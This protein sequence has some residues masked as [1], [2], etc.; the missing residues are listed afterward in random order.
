[1]GVPQKWREHPIKMD[2]LGLPRFMETLNCWYKSW[3]LDVP[4]RYSLDPLQWFWDFSSRTSQFCDAATSASARAGPR[5]D[6]RWDAKVWRVTT[7][8][9]T[10]IPTMEIV[11]PAANGTSCRAGVALGIIERGD[12]KCKLGK[13][14]KRQKSGRAQISY[15]PKYAFYE[16]R[17]NPKWYL[18]WPQWQVPPTTPMA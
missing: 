10:T 13:I 8:W 16:T 11:F 3:F 4:S 7:A 12:A 6:V 15:P 17:N 9:Q 2:H 14:I 1:M 18:Q 5:A